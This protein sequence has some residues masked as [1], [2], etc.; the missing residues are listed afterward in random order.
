MYLSLTRGL[1][2]GS[3]LAL[4]LLPRKVSSTENNQGRVTAFLQSEHSKSMFLATHAG[5]DLI[6]FTDQRYKPPAECNGVNLSKPA[7]P[8]RLGWDPPVTIVGMDASN[9][10]A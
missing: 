2:T 1:E 10:G 4:Y 9:E 3:L 7:R 6:K 8:A 5:Y